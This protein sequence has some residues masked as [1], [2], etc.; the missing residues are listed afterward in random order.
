MVALGVIP[1]CGN[2][3]ADSPNDLN[4]KCEGERSF[5]TLSRVKNHLRA[6]MSQDRLDDF[7]VLSI[8]SDLLLLSMS[9][10]LLMILHMKN[11]VNEHFNYIVKRY[12]YMLSNLH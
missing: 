4:Y 2:C 9:Q 6:T 10:H 12:M 5:L 7:A 8:K 3:F 1:E 11:L